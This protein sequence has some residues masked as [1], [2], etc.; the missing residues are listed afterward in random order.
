MVRYATP[1][2]IY[3]LHMM[4]KYQSSADAHATVQKWLTGRKIGQ[5]RA[6]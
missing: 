1:V 6:D 2:M 4:R 3:F 5:K